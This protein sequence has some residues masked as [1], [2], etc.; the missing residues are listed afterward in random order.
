MNKKDITGDSNA[1]KKDGTLKDRYFPIY[2]DPVSGKVSTKKKLK[3]KVLPID[4]N[5]EKRIWRRSKEDVDK[6]YEEGEI[7]G[8]DTKKNGLQ[9]YFKFRGGIDGEP[10]KSMWYDPKFSASEHGTKVLRDILGERE[11]FEYPKSIHAVMECIKIMT[12]NDNAIVLDFFAGSGTTGQ[13]VLELNKLDGKNRS[14]IICTNNENDICTEVT[15]PRIKNV[16]NGYNFKGEEKVTIYKNKLTVSKL[17]RFSDIIDEM[18][19]V[20]ESKVKLYDKIETKLKDNTIFIIGIK[21]HN[22]KKKGLGGHLK[23][24]KTDFINVDN[25]GSISDKRKIDLTYQAGELIALKEGAYYELEKNNNWQ[26]FK[27]A[28]NIVGIYFSE[29]QSDLEKIFKKFNGE[30][31][32]LYIFSWGKNSFNGS[33]YGHPNI[34]IKDIPQPIIEVYK[35]INKLRK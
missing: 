24:Y 15:L 2:Y 23:Y 22:G 6:M 1:D 18:A 17:N 35:E 28:D 25:V 3:V 8:K 29:D 26:I 5:G 9:I 33:D 27:G 32:I 31:G 19:K 13:A 4:P 30:A 20:T 10:P 21:K 16:I 11:K 14:F 12:Q 34:F 7:W